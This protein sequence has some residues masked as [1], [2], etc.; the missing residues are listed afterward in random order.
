MREHWDT[1]IDD[2]EKK[3]ESKWRVHLSAAERKRFTRLKRVVAAFKKELLNNQNQYNLQ[4]NSE[5][6]RPSYQTS[7]GLREACHRKSY[8]S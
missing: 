7:C 4:N 2:R 8:C 3:E 6:L 5:N 1:M